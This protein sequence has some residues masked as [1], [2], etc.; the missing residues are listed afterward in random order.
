[1]LDNF[2][3]IPEAESLP[4]YPSVFF[5]VLNLDYHILLSYF[6]ITLHYANQ[7]LLLTMYGNS[8][9]CLETLLSRKLY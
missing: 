9:K 1:M 4:S 8:T 3:P 2:L 5:F 7:S 6:H